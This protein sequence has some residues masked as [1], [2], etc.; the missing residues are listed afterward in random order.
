MPDTLSLLLPSHCSRYFLRRCMLRASQGKKGRQTEW[1]LCVQIW[2]LLKTHVQYLYPHPRYILN[3]VNAATPDEA[4]GP[5]SLAKL[6]IAKRE[7][8]GNQCQRCRVSRCARI[9]G[10]CTTVWWD[11]VWRNAMPISSALNRTFQTNICITNRERNNNCELSGSLIHLCITT[12]LLEQ[13]WVV[14]LCLSDIL[15]LLERP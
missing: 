11:G 14:Q 8:T 4:Q 6:L 5:R 9:A 12:L 3:N 2:S 13:P 1:L 7:G 10:N 15:I